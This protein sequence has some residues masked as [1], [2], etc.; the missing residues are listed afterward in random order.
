MLETEIDF[1]DLI[2]PPDTKT[3]RFDKARLVQ[4]DKGITI[5]EITIFNVR[6]VD[7]SVYTCTGENTFGT[8]QAMVTLAGRHHTRTQSHTVRGLDQF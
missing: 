7:Y 5:S 3:N 6:A 8:D 4:E 2:P 1:Q